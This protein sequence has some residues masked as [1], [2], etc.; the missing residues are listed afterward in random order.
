MFLIAMGVVA[1]I[2]LKITGNDG[3]K[4]NVSND[5]WKQ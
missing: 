4:A 3:G 5:Q 1:V 2:V